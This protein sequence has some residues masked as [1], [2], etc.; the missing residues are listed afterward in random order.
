MTFWLAVALIV[1]VAVGIGTQHERRLW[2]VRHASLVVATPSTAAT[3]PPVAGQIP[4]E[5]APPIAWRAPWLSGLAAGVIVI[6]I[7]LA[8]E[9]SAREFA[10]AEPPER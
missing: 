1:G 8:A 7:G 5:Q 9:A 3:S 6:C 10:A 4:M 2:D